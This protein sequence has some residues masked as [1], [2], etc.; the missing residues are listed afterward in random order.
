MARRFAVDR[1]ALG[2]DVVAGDADVAWAGD[3]GALWVAGGRVPWAAGGV[4]ASCAVA[5]SSGILMRSNDNAANF[6][7]RI[8]CIFQPHF[9]PNHYYHMPRTSPYRR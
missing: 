1:G 5:R 4:E 8:A 9:V 6:V 2:V 7:T 3:A